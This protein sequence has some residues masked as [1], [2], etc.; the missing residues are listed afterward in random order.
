MSTPQEYGAASQVRSM[1]FESVTDPND[2]RPRLIAAVYVNNQLHATS[3]PFYPGVQAGPNSRYTLPNGGQEMRMSRNDM[4]VRALDWSYNLAQELRREGKQVWS[5]QTDL[6]LPFGTCNGCKVRQGMHAT[7]ISEIFPGTY[8]AR[9]QKWKIAVKPNYDQQYDHPATA[10]RSDRRTGEVLTTYGYE[11]GVE[12]KSNA[13]TQDH[14]PGVRDTYWQYSHTPDGPIGT[15]NPQDNTM[16]AYTGPIVSDRNSPDYSSPSNSTGGTP[17]KSNTP[18]NGDPGG[19]NTQGDN[20]QSEGH[21]P[22]YDKD[23]GTYVVEHNGQTLYHNPRT[24]EWESGQQGSSTSASQSQKSFASAV[25]STQPAQQESSGRT[26]GQRSSRHGSSK[27]SQSH[28]S[29][30]RRKSKR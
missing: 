22:Y 16:N 27:D 10:G 15:V 1:A 3:D 7:D 8:D 13:Y 25:K 2:T 6:I 30:S 9:D 20:T 29:S 24:G 21:E 5:Y 14:Y 11:E 19:D 12:L 28:G 17:P 4:E 26:S 18:P 23:A